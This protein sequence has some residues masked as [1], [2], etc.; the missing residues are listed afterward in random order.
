MSAASLVL[1]YDTGAFVLGV[2]TCRLKIGNFGSSVAVKLGEGSYRLR[3]SLRRAVTLCPLSLQCPHSPTALTVPERTVLEA[4]YSFPVT[5]AVL[6]DYGHEL[7]QHSSRNAVRMTLAT[8]PITASV[9]HG[10]P[11]SQ[12]ISRDGLWTALSQAPPTKWRF[13]VSRCQYSH[14][15]IF[16]NARVKN[17]TEILSRYIYYAIALSIR[18]MADCL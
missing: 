18:A 17:L 9:T 14:G 15:V 3:S 13:S 5:S 10:R 2:G 12:V 16:S 6:S 8:P 11:S 4:S 7:A 1:E